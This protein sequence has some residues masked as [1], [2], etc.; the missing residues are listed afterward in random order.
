MIGVYVHNSGRGHLYRVLPVVAA[1]RECGEDVTLLFSG[2]FD[3]A[4]RPP[5]TRVVHLPFDDRVLASSRSPGP[6]PDEI[7]LPVR[8]S[9]VSW[10]DRMRPRAF[11]VDSSPAMALAAGMTGTPMISTL[12]PGVRRDEPHRLSCGISDR[13]IGAWPPGVHEETVAVTDHRVSEVGGISRFERRD[14]SRRRRRRP[15]VVHLNGAGDRGDHR[16]WRA[17]RR[18]TESR[19]VA[20]WLDLGGLDGAWNDD[21]WEA[22]TSAD[23]VVTG[24]GQSSVADA[25]CADV[26]IVVVPERREHG[27]H[28]ATAEALAATPGAAVMSYGAGPT[29][30]AGV[31]RDQVERSREEGATG[32]RQWWGIDGAAA[33]A[34]EVIR[35]TT[36]TSSPGGLRYPS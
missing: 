21:P 24:A 7:S 36:T 26:P 22:L 30:V 29:A 20:E 6:D 14:L 35:T 13:L 17:V 10:L 9:V 2:S 28:D 23:V 16:F 33:R 31:V 27:E 25:A 12:P 11:W 8:R 15:R 4:L 1:L 3:E 18:A 19:R 32:I 5:G 34:A